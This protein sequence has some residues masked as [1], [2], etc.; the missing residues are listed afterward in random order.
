MPT[1]DENPGYAPSL[2]SLYFV[3][4]FLYDVSCLVRTKHPLPILGLFVSDL[5]D[6]MFESSILRY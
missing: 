6:A 4:I 5:Y 2:Y 1:P 3:Y